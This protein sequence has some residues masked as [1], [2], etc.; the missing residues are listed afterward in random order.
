MARTAGTSSA[1]SSVTTSMASAPPWARVGAAARSST[2][3]K[4]TRKRDVIRSMCRKT[5]TAVPRGRRTGF[6]GL[7]RSS[8]RPVATWMSARA[9]VE[10]AGEVADH[11]SLARLLEPAEQTFDPD[12][13]SFR[14]MP[15][16]NRQILVRIDRQPSGL[17]L[18]DTAARDQLA[19]LLHLALLVGD[20][21]EGEQVE[22]RVDSAPAGEADALLDLL[23]PVLDGLVVRLVQRLVRAVQADATG[24]EP[25]VDQQR[26]VLRERPVRVHVDRSA[27]GPRAHRPDGLRDLPRA[28]QRLAFAA[29]PEGDHG[30]SRGRREVLRADARHLLR[31]RR[32]RQALV[33]GGRAVLGLLG[34]A[35]DAARVAPRA[36]RDGALV[37]FI[38]RVLGGEAAVFE[39]AFR[40]L[41]E[42]RVVVAREARLDARGKIGRRVGG[43]IP[44]PPLVGVK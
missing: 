3:G 1:P 29:L 5:A 18:V 12:P 27:R 17:D 36:G 40:E 19:E 20:A 28:R 23:P 21:G 26:E 2:A 10:G 8:T 24:V 41:A 22:R 7:A 15:R 30:A 6:Q 34:D 16:R 37:P 13:R 44:V 14:R 25:G 42:Q 4:V 31:A 35:S 33:R 11:Q 38:E 9:L 39:R 32:A 43:R